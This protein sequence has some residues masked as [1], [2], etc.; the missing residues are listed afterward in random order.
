[1]KHLKMFED[2]N[3]M[4]LINEA[5]NKDMKA[6]GTDLGKYL[7]NSKFD[8]KFLNGPITQ[9]Q[10]KTL[11][12]SEGIVALEVFEN[13]EMQTLFLYFNP[14]QIKTIESVVGKFQLSNYMGPVLKRDWTT[15]QVK[16]ALNPGDIFKSDHNKAQGVMEFYRVANVDRKVMNK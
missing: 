4:K 16:G 1:M 13:N 15:K 5:L 8:V 10:K 9:D 11:M 6:F 14:K 12:D 3:G 2:Y 7:K